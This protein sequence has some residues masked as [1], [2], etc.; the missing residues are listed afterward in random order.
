MALN[1]AQIAL[2]VAFFGA[3]A[4]ILGVVAENKKPLFGTRIEGKG[5]IIC[6]YPSDP[7]VALGSISIVALLFSALLGVLSVFYPYKGKSVPNATLFSST[8][9][10]VFL[11]VAGVVTVL[12]EAMMV[13]VTITEG[14][15][16]AYNTHHN[17]DAECATAKTGLFGGAAF[18]ALNAALFWLICQMLAL[19]V[20]EDY[21]CEDEDELKGQYGNVLTTEYDTNGDGAGS[22]V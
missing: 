2:A 17:M 3:V 15:H 11:I 22:K 21:L 1:T 9:L 19:N 5:V 4:F 6:Q 18:M 14:L 8:T 16:R 10:V 7:T 12:G 13:W 20:R